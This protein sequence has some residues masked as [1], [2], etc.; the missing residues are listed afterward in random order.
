MALI[1]VLGCFEVSALFCFFV[2]S[3]HMKER[4]LDVDYARGTSH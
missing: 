2:M 1:G 4:C 3:E